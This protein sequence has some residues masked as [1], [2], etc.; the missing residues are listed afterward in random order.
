MKI[1]KFVGNGTGVPGLPHV[2]KQSDGDRW[3]KEAE[4]AKDSYGMP[5][6]ILKGALANKNY[7]A[8]STVKGKAP[9]E[10]PSEEKEK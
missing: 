3:M 2:I 7:I 9:P 4:R 1:Y 6:A 8:T 5:G 10:K